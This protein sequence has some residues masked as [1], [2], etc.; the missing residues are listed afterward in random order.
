MIGGDGIHPADRGISAGSVPYTGLEPSDASTVKEELDWRAR[1]TG[2]RVVVNSYA[3]LEAVYPAVADV[4][5]IDAVVDL[6]GPIALPLGVRIVLTSTGA[7]FS[8]FAV[9]QTIS[10]SYAG[11]LV[12]GTNLALQGVTLVNANAAGSHIASSGAGT[13]VLREVICAGPAAVGQLS[14]FGNATIEGCSWVGCA[15]GLEFAGVF[16]GVRVVHC[17]A[18]TMPAS[19]AAFIVAAAA[20]PTVGISWVNNTLVSDQLGQSL[21]RIDAAAALPAG[22]ITMRL[23][24]NAV[25]RIGAGAGVVLDQAGIIE[26][27]ARVIATTNLNGARSLFL[28]HASFNDPD[29]PIEK[30]Y[31][32]PDVYETIPISNGVTPMSLVATSQRFQLVQDGSTWYLEYIGLMPTVTCTVQWIATVRLGGGAPSE[33]SFRVEYWQFGVGTWGALDGSVGIQTQQT[34]AAQSVSGFAT[35]ELSTNDRLRLTVA[36]TDSTAGTEFSS[37]SIEADGVV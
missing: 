35:V 1:H 22:L 23:Q 8:A 2:G 25:P 30:S 12:T 18:L 32:A 20:A 28:G 24:G 5:T 21:V 6:T 4:H 29:V 11:A 31:S 3:D 13:T 36:N 33:L 37:I 9:R 15:S 34:T 16:A 19:S 27:D 14:N 26:S 7:L 17:T 10:G